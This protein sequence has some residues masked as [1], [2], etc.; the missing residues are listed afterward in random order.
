MSHK[1]QKIFLWSFTSVRDDGMHLMSQSTRRSSFYRV[2]MF[3]TV[4]YIASKVS[5]RS[6]YGCVIVFVIFA[7][8]ENLRFA[9]GGKRVHATM[10]TILCWKMF[11]AI[12]QNC[13]IAIGNPFMHETVTLKKGVCECLIKLLCCRVWPRMHDKDF[14]ANDS[15]ERDVLE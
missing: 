3:A 5:R 4:G 14:Y 15:L 9:R 7:Q 11:L 10:H 6:V 13:L 2:G 8:I 12:T 1:Y